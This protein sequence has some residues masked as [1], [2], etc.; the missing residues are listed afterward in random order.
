MLEVY[1]FLM[2]LF[3]VFLLLEYMTLTKSVEKIP[4][5]ILVNGIR[6]KTTTV[7]ILY[8][9]LKQSDYNVFAKTTGDQA[10]EFLADGTTKTIRRRSPTSIIENVGILRKWSKKHPDAIVVESMA[11]HP[12]N[13][14]MLAEKMIKPTHMIITNILH[15]HFETMG[16]DIQSISRTLQESFYSK[17]QKILPENY[18]YFYKPVQNT[19]YYKSKL[20]EIDFPNIPS[21]VINKN[22]GLINSICVELNLDLEIAYNKFHE[23]WKKSNNNIRI[24]NKKLNFEFWNLFSVNDYDSSKLFIEHIMKKESNKYK[25]EIIF[26]TRFDRP[27]RTKSFIPLLTEY[28]SNNLIVLVGSGSNLAFRHLKKSS[29]KNYSKISITDI[30]KKFKSGFRNRTLIIGIGN[31]FGM[32][33]LI[34]E[35]K[36]LNSGENL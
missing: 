12:E 24:K 25:L 20:F 22:W 35:I 29:C 7:K 30:D 13:Q 28:F 5:R 21:E 15:D 16:N 32:N 31:H 11:L 36:L 2:I 19:L 17:A 9:I 6:G 14:R 27:L 10:V 3:I 8:N 1:F 34:E 18:S 33:D 23:E 4:I 26:N